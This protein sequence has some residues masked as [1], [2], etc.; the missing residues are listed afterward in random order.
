[1]KCFGRQE[2]LTMSPTEKAALT[3]EEGKTESGIF[4]RRTSTDT[5]QGTLILVMGYG[6]S[7]RIW[8]TTFVERLAEKFAVVTYDNRGTGLSIIPEQA[9]EYTIKLMS[10]DLFDVVKALKIKEHHL[11]GYS[12]G[13]CIALQYAYDHSEIVKS[14]FLM[15]GTAGGIEYVKPAKEISSALANPQGKTL[16]DIYMYTWQLMYSPDHFE[17]CQPAFKAIYET[18]KDTP[19]RPLA[20]F[21]HSHAFRGFDGSTFLEKLKMPTTILAGRNDR[22]MPFSNSENLTKIVGSRLVAIDDCEHGPHIQNEADVIQEIERTC[23]A[24]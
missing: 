10:D 17:R 8:P 15:S 19:T 23:S 11:L 7:L 5:S 3:Q 9:D 22:L 18:S 13:S 24:K 1:V 14:L 21:G 20:L 4:Y 12:M 6:G 2:N 16:W